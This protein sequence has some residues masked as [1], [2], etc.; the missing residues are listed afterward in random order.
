MSGWIQA[1]PQLHLL[2]PW[3]LLGLLALPLL[4]R[5]WRAPPAGGAWRDAVDAHLLPHLLDA[6]ASPRRAWARRL[7]LAAAA[8]ALLALA[9]PSLR[10]EP[11]PLWQARAPLVVAL[12]LARATLARDLPPSRIAQAR[13]KLAALLRGREGGQVA[14][15]AFADDAYTVAP[16]TDDAANLALFLDALAPDV[17][18]A[19]GHRADRAIAWSQGLLRQAGFPAGEILLLT[20]RAD[21]DALAAAASARAA[22]YR[23]SVLGLGRAGGGPVDGAPALEVEALRRLAARGG[24]AYAT[25][26]PDDADL[27]ALGVLAPRADAGAAPGQARGQ[28][29]RDDGYWL[30]PLALLL[31]LPLFRRGGGAAAALL[32]FALLLPGT[33]A[34]AQEAD[35]LWRRPDQQAFA[36]MQD[37]IDAYRKGDYQAAIARFSGNP[38][39]DGQYNLGNALAKAGR[40]DA[41]I[42]AYDRALALQPKMADAIANRAAVEAA[43][44]R[45]PPPG[46][47]QQ[48]QNPQQKPQ[49]PGQ[50]Q[51][52]QGEGQDAPADAA[53]QAPPQSER[54][55]PAQ[56]RPQDAQQQADA[57]AAQ[58][59]RMQDAL[60]R[61]PKPGQ[62]GQ[63]QTGRPPETAAQRERRL[64]NQAQL[65]RVPD[66]PGALLRARFR[67]EYERRRGNLP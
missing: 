57:D 67:L 5:A 25:L 41:A 30:L 9:G 12:D 27:R 44:R 42:A 49:S 54:S 61:Q 28:R 35:P 46:G 43:R 56:G 64:A 62:A 37:G 31:A 52:R 51:P 14:L 13:A 50:G 36:R 45:K 47:G 23:V 2:R 18:P 22:G 60:R 59:Q 40:Y 3:W 11:V 65:Q 10:R 7:G 32:A 15:V 6:G 24:G 1:L 66:D 58:R 48:Q 33:P 17:M 53:P 20:D 39:A 21:A 63:A 29:W 4:A 19:D 8:V 16:L 55:D 34:R 26:T 38:T